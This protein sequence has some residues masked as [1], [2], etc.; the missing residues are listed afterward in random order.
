MGRRVGRGGG[1]VKRYAH[2]VGLNIVTSID[3]AFGF[4]GSA[5]AKSIHCKRE[6]AGHEL[7]AFK[8]LRNY[9]GSLYLTSNNILCLSITI[10]HPFFE[11]VV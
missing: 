7:A 2:L 3:F 5:L 11:V 1:E 8:I 6:F 10:A 9:K 4:V